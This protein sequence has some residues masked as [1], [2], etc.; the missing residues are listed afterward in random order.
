MAIIRHLKRIVLLTCVGSL[1]FLLA[2]ITPPP[3]EIESGIVKYDIRVDAPLTPETNLSVKGRE[4]L[5][6]KDWGK[7]KIEEV[8]GLVVTQGAIQYKESVK[9]FQKETKETIITADFENEQLLERKKSSIAKDI[10]RIE[11]QNLIKTGTE[12][13][14]G[15]TCNIWESPGIKKCIYKGIILKFESHVYD[16]S[17]VKVATEAVFDINT[18][19][20]CAVPD[21]PVQEFG[22]FTDNIKTKNTAKSEDFCKVINE[23]MSEVEDHN[24]SYSGSG[25]EDPNRIKFINHISQDIFEKQKELLPQLLLSMKKMRECL[26]TVENPFEANQ[27]IE[28]FSSMKSKLGNDENDYIILW[29]QKRKNT[30]LDKIE[31][32]LIDLESRIACVNRA[33]NINDLSTCLK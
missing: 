27:C 33:Q 10:H 15:L 11:T 9:R 19:E 8:K 28:D 31:D 5:R 2:E 21:Y 7:V 14:A 3:F 30:L 4:R 17:Y 25:F 22:L 13:I 12:T 32:E 23:V 6:F 1:N 29:D 24:E 16:V 26:Q 18:S 20:D